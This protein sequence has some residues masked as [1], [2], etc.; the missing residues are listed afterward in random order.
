MVEVRVSRVLQAFSSAFRSIDLRIAAVDH[1]GQFTNVITSM[2]FSYKSPEELELEQGKLRA[3]MPSGDFLILLLGFPFAGASDL[4]RQL[5][6][7]K[8]KIFPPTHF[9]ELNMTKIKVQSRPDFLREIGEWNLVGS[10]VD[11]KKGDEIWDIVDSH[12]GQARL[13]GYKDSYDLINEILGIRGFQRGKKE[14]LVIGI[15]VLARIADVRF[16][17]SKMRIKTRKAASLEDLQLNIYQRRPSKRGGQWESVSRSRKPILVKRCKSSSRRR[18]CTVT[19]SINL[20]TAKPYDLVEVELIHKGEPSLSMDTAGSRVPLVNVT[21]PL[22]KTLFSFCS[23]NEFRERLLHPEKHKNPSIVFENAV[24]WLLSLIGLS[25]LQLGKKFE[26][27]RVYETKF[28]RGSVD[29]IAYKESEYLVLVDCDTAIPDEKKVRSMTAL[30]QYFESLQ[31]AQGEPRICPV[32]ISPRDC[33][34]LAI[35]AFNV[36]KV[37]GGSGIE[38]IFEEAMKGNVKGAI[39]SLL[40]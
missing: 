33:S 6:K 10:K 40:F 26:K 11:S 31:T 32:I 18:F 3:T 35:D 1:E 27:L 23:M 25:V 7:G 16:T 5:G 15:P 12:S 36:V 24:A 29:M 30:K 22:A 19:N 4:F 21:E 28:E 38:R 8:L 9:G 17:G 20:A 34:G 39:Y 13:S 37:V 14:A 2:F